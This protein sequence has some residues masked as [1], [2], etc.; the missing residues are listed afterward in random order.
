M[1]TR[2]TY[3]DDEIRA[4]VEKAGSIAAAARAL[5]A[6]ERSLRRRIKA[7]GNAEARQGYSPA[8]GMTKRVPDGYLVKGVSTLYDAEGN[9]RQQWVKS[10]IDNDRQRQLIAEAI[11]A[12][13]ED[14]PRIKPTR[15]PR[16]TLDHLLAVYPMGDPHIGML[17]WGEE[18]G[19]DYDLQIAERDLCAA[20]AYL[21]E[22]AP[23]AKRA[24]IANL[25]DFF[26]ADNMAGVTSRSGH[27]LD[28]D[29][30]LPK[31][32]RVGVRVMRQLIASALEK[33][34]TVEVVNAIGNHD[35]VLS[36]ALSI[37]LAN[38][39][40]NEPRIVIHDQPTPRHYIRH[41]K[42]LIGITHGHTTKDAELPLIMA[43][44]RHA[45]WGQT[46]HRYWYRGHHH[47]DAKKEYN[48]CIV[49]QFRTLAAGDAYAVSHGYLS[50]RDMKCIV[51]H[52]EYGEV[53]RTVCSVDMLRAAT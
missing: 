46:L 12:M 40:E 10:H 32:V 26:H 22:Q 5:G 13:C 18:T 43:T 29:S 3:S 44:E 50:G 33:H 39:Y 7:M 34:E 51:H 2:R 30:R 11:E 19:A 35:D 27:V 49:E 8:H 53:A 16:Q 6:N 21:V 36:M 37:M 1:T 4:A 41:G 31:M 23:P 9:I 38:I 20:M 25:G 15:G 24:L 45:E 17:S 52:A 28:M 42:V 14:V 47:H 48:G